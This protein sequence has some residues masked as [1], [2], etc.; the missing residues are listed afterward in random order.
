[1][2]FSKLDFYMAI[3]YFG[4]EVGFSCWDM[5]VDYVEGSNPDLVEVSK[6]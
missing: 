6:I 5:N 1:M 3:I 2:K 4:S